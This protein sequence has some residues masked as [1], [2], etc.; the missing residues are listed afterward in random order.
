MGQGEE[1]G[2]YFGWE[3]S[4][5]PMVLPF[6]NIVE[7]TDVLG[8]FL[9]LYLLRREPEMINCYSGIAQQAVFKGP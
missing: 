7:V 5:R 9:V 4:E 3:L 8:V 2:Y 1:K 6:L